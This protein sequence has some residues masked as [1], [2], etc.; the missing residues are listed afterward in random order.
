MLGC[1]GIA[2][3]TWPPTSRAL[4]LSSYPMQSDR[5]L[6]AL[7]TSTA[8]VIAAACG[9]NAVIDPGGG[10]GGAG[11]SSTSSSG[12]GGTTTTSSSGTG[13]TGGGSIAE[14]CAQI[15]EVLEECS[16][17]YPN[18]IQEC[19]MGLSPGCQG[20]YYAYLACLA[21]F[22]S[23]PACQVPSQCEDEMDL[24]ESCGVG[25]GPCT[26]GP[27]YSGS[28]GSCGC[29]VVCPD[30]V[31]ATDCTPSGGAQLSCTCSIDDNPI[32]SC[33]AQL[34]MEACDVY[35]GCCAPLFFGFE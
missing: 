34:S 30:G 9:G 35:S 15:C 13:G 23:P 27:C 33:S 8:L 24:Y 28:D 21:A 32:G 17:A 26:G 14:A 3:A 20:E 25:P 22:M 7:F 1:Q 10:V 2:P 11:A 18:C 31:Y 6:T 4:P 5:P 29:E 12:T 19:Q 16:P